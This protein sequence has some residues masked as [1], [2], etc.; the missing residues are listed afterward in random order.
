GA[1]A[2]QPGPVR[3]GDR[4]AHAAERVPL[5]QLPAHRAGHP[6]GG[7]GDGR[8]MSLPPEPPQTVDAWLRLEE[9][10]AVVV[11]TGKVEVGQNIRTALGQVVAEELRVPVDR[12]SVVMADTAR[13]P[14][15]MGTFG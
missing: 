10:G 1:A 2:A 7:R 8:P 3:R 13:V 15:D 12:V 14:F 4:P 11:L 6:A 5:R 9:D